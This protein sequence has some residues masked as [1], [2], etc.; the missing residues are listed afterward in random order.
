[1]A[2]LHGER[3][4]WQLPLTREINACGGQT[5]SLVKHMISKPKLIRRA[6]VSPSQKVGLVDCQ[7]GGA[8]ARKL[9]SRGRCAHLVRV[10]NYVTPQFLKCARITHRGQRRKPIDH[11]QFTASQSNR[12][13]AL[14]DAL[15]RGLKRLWR[16]AFSQSE[17][18][19]Q[20]A[21]KPIFAG[22]KGGVFNPGDIRSIAGVAKVDVPAQ[23]M[24][25]EFGNRT[26]WRQMVNSKT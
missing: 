6:G 11:G 16:D 1:M 7:P 20:R 2:R 5:A 3:L 23:P 22:C 8:A 25:P 12:R 14:G 15:N 26:H 21:M 17:W 18:W 4:R 19:H 9:G 13:V 10:C 24:S